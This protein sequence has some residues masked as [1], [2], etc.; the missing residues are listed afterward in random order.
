M[1]DFKKAYPLILAHEGGYV[2]DP[3]DPGGETYKGV[4]RKMHP[5]WLGWHIVDM[6]KAKPGFPDALQSADAIEIKKQLDLELS[7]F[8]YA[9]YWLKIQGDLIVSQEVANSMFD[10]AINA[11]ETTSISLAQVVV[12]TKPDGQI[13]PKT[14]EA[15][16][17]FDGGQFLTAFALAKISR[18]VEICTKRPTSKKY[19]FGWVVRSLNHIQ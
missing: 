2:N 9:H 5:D 12:G 13:G 11:G 10:F 18:Y 14:L 7:S 6:I 19:F 8:Y 17:R 3:D 1:A 16:N 4:A 15:I